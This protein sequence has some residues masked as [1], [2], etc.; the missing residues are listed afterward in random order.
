MYN[1]ILGCQLIYNK[2]NVLKQ[3]KLLTTIL[4][5]H[6]PWLRSLLHHLQVIWLAL[7][8]FCFLF[9]SH[10]SWSHCLFSLAVDAPCLWHIWLAWPCVTQMS[11]KLL[12]YG[13]YKFINHLSLTI[14]DKR[15]GA[16]FKL[17]NDCYRDWWIWFAILHT[18]TQT[19]GR[20]QQRCSNVHAIVVF[21]F[22]MHASFISTLIFF[23]HSWDRKNN[24][25]PWNK[26]EPTDQYKVWYMCRIV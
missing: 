22:I 19:I 13:R 4:D 9:T 12:F 7:Y 11:G 5:G 25:E 24:P 6:Q 8:L 1:N 17:R 16:F 26:M 21:S 2:I 15:P 10:H 14:D 20:E 3:Y 18:L 23:I